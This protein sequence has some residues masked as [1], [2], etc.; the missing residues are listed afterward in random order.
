MPAP[1]GRSSAA[2]RRPSGFSAP[3]GSAAA[4]RGCRRRRKGQGESGAADGG[5]LAALSAWLAGPPPRE[6][7]ALGPLTNLAILALAHPERARQIRRITWMGGARTR[8]NHTPAAEFNA[9]AD[10]EAVAI[11]LARRIPLRM[12]DLDACRQV[13]ITEADRAALAG[14]ARP[15]GPAARFVDLLGGWLDI[16][17]E[18]GRSA[19]PLYDP[20]AAAALLQPECFTFRPVRLE[21]DLADA[22][23]RGRTRVAPA[24]P[25][26]AEVV[27]TLDAE[28]I[29]R[30][31]L[32][33]LEAAG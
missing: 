8:G 15:G 20:V 33:A 26:L 9:F 3:T 30:G 24:P 1:G 19:M 5:A 25:A 27:E 16:A 11:L 18:R 28:P 7:L 21:I 17:R 23:E 31:C 29:R 6:V 10:P 13:V 14:R 32:A 12:I 4:A 2:G 22:E